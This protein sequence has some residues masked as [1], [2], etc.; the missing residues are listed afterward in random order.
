MLPPIKYKVHPKILEIQEEKRRRREI[1]EEARQK[2]TGELQ[3]LKADRQEYMQINKELIQSKQQAIYEG[4]LIKRNR[5]REEDLG[6]AERI[7]NKK[8]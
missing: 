3:S 1:L 4:K 7:A 5:I 6:R 2:E 8:S